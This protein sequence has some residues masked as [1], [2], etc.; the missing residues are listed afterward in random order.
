MVR[1]VW[2]HIAE[3]VAGYVPLWLKRCYWGYRLDHEW[4]R[5]AR[6]GRPRR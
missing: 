1:F 2:W 5:L 6:Q 3:R 4:D